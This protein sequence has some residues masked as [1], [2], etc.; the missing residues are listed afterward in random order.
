MKSGKEQLAID[1]I[2]RKSDAQDNLVKKYAVDVSRPKQH[3]FL[4]LSDR[5]R[6]RMGSWEEAY[7]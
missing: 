1:A 6:P 7:Q 5:K 2:H 3:A 4:A